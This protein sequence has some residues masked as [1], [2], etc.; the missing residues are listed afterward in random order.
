MCIKERWGWRLELLLMRYGKYLIT[1]DKD[2]GLGKATIEDVTET[3]NWEMHWL[4]DSALS[5][6][7]SLDLLAAIV[8]D[9]V[10]PNEQWACCN[11]WERERVARP[12]P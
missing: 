10:K 11:M 2:E 12:N 4:D 1:V 7:K 9:G 3:E 6:Y 5:I 8:V